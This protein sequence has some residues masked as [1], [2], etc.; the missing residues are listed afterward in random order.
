MRSLI[1]GVGEIGQAYYDILKPAY[2][3]TYRLDLIP[4]RSDKK[5]P[6]DVDI[7]HVCLRYS[8]EWQRQVKE[9]IYRFHPKIVNVMTTVPPGTSEKLEEELP[10]SVCHST[11]RGLHP[12]LSQFIR[13]TKKHIGGKAAEE[14]ALYFKCAGLSCITHARATI[15]ETLHIASNLQYAASLLFANE[16]ESFL[17]A[18]A[19]DWY[20]FERYSHSHN[21]GYAAMGM[22]GKMRPIIYPPGKV[23]AGHCLIPNSKLV[24]ENQRGP[25]MRMLAD[26][27]N[28]E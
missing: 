27:S 7:L 17:R 9:A 23:I 3:Q 22:I 15:T 8:D 2:P 21:E 1:L 5:L 28:V 16:L 26:S 13:A 11:T 18:N 4:E 12:N 14:V 6:K 24:P 25:V 10:V 20:E 19:V